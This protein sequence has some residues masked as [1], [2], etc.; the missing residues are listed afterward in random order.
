MK[1]NEVEKLCLINM[2][3]AIAIA[4]SAIMGDVFASFV[5]M[6]TSGGFGWKQ[7]GGLMMSTLLFSV[8]VYYW[9]YYRL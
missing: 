8:N 4:L 2:G 9:R 7:S 1:I 5:G 6:E 3:I